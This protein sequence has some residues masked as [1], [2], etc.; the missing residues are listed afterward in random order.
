MRR[1]LTATAAGIALVVAAAAAMLTPGQAGAVPDLSGEWTF[2]ISGDF[3]PPFGEQTL[4]CTTEM[5]HTGNEIA[6]TFQCGVG[7]GSGTG[8]ISQQGPGA[9]IEAHLELSVSG[10]GNVEADATGTV[11]PDGNTMQGAWTSGSL[12]TSGDFIAYRTQLQYLQGDLNCDGA[13]NALDA[14]TALRH[15]L[16]AEVF[17]HEGC[18]EIES[19]FASLFGDLN[20]DEN[21]GPVDAL[22]ILRYG[23]GLPL[24]AIDG[25]T[26]VG[27]LIFGPD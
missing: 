9:Q 21:V 26:A 1:T 11:A 25:C 19:E 13:V 22:R 17:Q 20:C 10:G 27:A 8:T 7:N 14:L 18:P 16:G 3:G 6:A 4:I 5:T 2:E 23:G 15:D 12:S 24:Q